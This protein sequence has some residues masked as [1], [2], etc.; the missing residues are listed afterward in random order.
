MTA[1]RD[2]KERAEGITD[3]NTPPD[4]AS[5]TQADPSVGN[6][7]PTGNVWHDI[8]DALSLVTQ[9]G[10]SMALCVVLGV[11]SGRALDRWFGTS[12]V[13]LLIGALLGGAASIKVLYDLAIKKWM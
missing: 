7:V 11:L 9:L 4:S 3:A 8:A 1:M 2:P 6:R 5:D 10:F 13:L 12:P